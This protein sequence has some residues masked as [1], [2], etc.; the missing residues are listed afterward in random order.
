MISEIAHN[1]PSWGLGW[2]SDELRQTRGRKEHCRN[3]ICSVYLMQYSPSTVVYQPAKAGLHAEAPHDKTPS[4]DDKDSKKSHVS[5]CS[6]FCWKFAKSRLTTY[7]LLVPLGSS[8]LGNGGKAVISS[9]FQQQQH[10]S[11]ALSGYWHDCQ[12]HPVTGLRIV[13]NQIN[14]PGFL[15]NAP[16]SS[17]TV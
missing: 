7:L 13:R 6:G 12:L 3:N 15:P 17:C 11:A 1:V 8:K 16:G 9:S 4:F 2:G 5:D 14:T 10:H